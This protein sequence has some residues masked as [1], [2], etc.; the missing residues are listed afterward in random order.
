MKNFQENDFKFIKDL[1]NGVYS[2][3]F[4]AEN[5]YSKN[6]YAIKQIK[7]HH[8]KGYLEA[9]KREIEIHTL[10]KKKSEFIIDLFGYFYSINNNQLHLV[11]EYMDMNLYSYQSKYAISINETIHI[12]YQVCKGVDYLHQY[13]IHKDLKHEN[14]MINVDSKKIK[15]ID[16]G[17]ST[18]L[19]KIDKKLKHTYVVTRYYRAPEIVYGV[20]YD[21]SVDIWSIACIFFEL[22]DNKPLFRSRCQ[23]D[24]SYKISELIGIPSTYSYQKTYTF[25]KYWVLKSNYY[26]IINYFK[27]DTYLNDEASYIYEFRHSIK[28]EKIKYKTPHKENLVPY[29]Y[30]CLESKIK[31]QTT[32]KFVV[33]FISKIIMY[34][35]EKRLT[36]EECL[37]H[38]V[39]LEYKINKFKL[40]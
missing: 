20:G 16:L 33:D 9:G 37:N 38:L 10:F 13:I 4:L 27:E 32:L 34:E 17:S 25:D 29:L 26:Q 21:K 1:G 15:I 7:I 19:N 12:M 11:F 8:N 22:F 2:K 30:T 28:T 35:S 5:V 3:V 14:I 39:F 23:Q 36:S 31:N 24:L 18:L 6:K 40:V